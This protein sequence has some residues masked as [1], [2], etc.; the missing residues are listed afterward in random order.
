MTLGEKAIVTIDDYTYSAADPEDSKAVFS[1]VRG[2]FYY[3]SGLIAE[4]EH[5]K[6]FFETPYGSVGARGTKFWGGMLERSHVY[7]S[8]DRMNGATKEFGVYA[9]KGEV[10]L[11]TNRGQ[12]II[13]EGYGSFAQSIDSV[14]S[15]PKV[16]G[17]VDI[18]MALKQVSFA[19]ENVLE[20]QA[21]APL[22]E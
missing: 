15:G 3:A 14:P 9:E 17:N 7:G 19:Q 2:A 22:N 10:V 12:S 8:A 18:G 5:P 4:Q 13:R 21:P 1:V 16:W 20:E 6:I 11:K